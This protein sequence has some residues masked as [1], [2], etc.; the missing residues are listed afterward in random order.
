MRIGI[1]ENYQIKQIDNIT[2]KS[3]TIIDLPEILTLEDGSIIEN[4]NFPF[5]NW[6]EETILQYC[7]EASENSIKIYPYIKL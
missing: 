1:N 7:Y 5:K 2:D 3:L 6:E 4:E